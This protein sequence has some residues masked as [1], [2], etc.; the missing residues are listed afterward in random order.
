MNISIKKVLKDIDWHFLFVDWK[1]MSTN[2]L[3]HFI[4]LFIFYHSLSTQLDVF[5]NFW[6]FLY[7]YKNKFSLKF[8]VYYQDT[9]YAKSNIE[10]HLTLKVIYYNKSL[11]N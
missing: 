8:V 5:S 6:Q 4:E 9:S 7:V 2:N 1:I 3:Q 11:K 10:I